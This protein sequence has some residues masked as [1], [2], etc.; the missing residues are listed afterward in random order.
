MKQKSPR[1][2]EGDMRAKWMICAVAIALVSSA[3]MAQQ[4]VNEDVGVSV[5]SWTVKS[6]PPADIV[7]FAW[8][9]T[10][11]PLTTL[12][13]LGGKCDQFNS[14]G[15]P[16]GKNTVTFENLILVGIDSE[17]MVFLSPQNSN[18]TKGKGEMAVWDLTPNMSSFRGDSV[19]IVGSAIFASKKASCRAKSRKLRERPSRTSGLMI[20]SSSVPV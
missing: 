17:N 4:W 10:L 3:A 12:Y 16:K 20:P 18:V 9:P 13:F 1:G 5:R 7:L 14:S 15:E 19:V 6:R 11:S 8:E 2:E